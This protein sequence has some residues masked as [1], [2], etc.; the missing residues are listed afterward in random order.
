M[1]TKNIEQDV[2]KW[3]LSSE[4]V[5]FLKDKDINNQL[6]IAIKLKFFE[7]NGYKLTEIALIS[8]ETIDYIAKSLKVNKSSIEYYDWSGRSSRRH[9]DAIR[10]YLG[11]RETE[12]QDINNLK[13]LVFEQFLPLAMSYDVIKEKVYSHL[14]ALKIEPLAVTTMERLLRSWCYQFEEEFFAKWANTLSLED[15]QSIDR[16]I[17]KTENKTEP[18]EITSE[19][20][21]IANST[22]PTITLNI[23]SNKTLKIEDEFTLN[24]LK[25]N[26]GR[27]SLDTVM[28]GAKKLKRLKEISILS[29]I[30]PANI[31]QLPINLV[32]KYHQQVMNIFPSEL[33]KMSD[34][35]RY[36]VL[37]CFSYY[38]VM[39]LTDSLIDML[40][41]LVHKVDIKA[42]KKVMKE[43]WNNRRETYDKDRVLNHLAEI[44][45]NNPKGIIEQEIY[46]KVS[47]EVLEAVLKKSKG[48]VYYRE[49]KFGHMRSSYARHYRRMIS[50]IFAELD[51]GANNEYE[52]ILEA[53]S[54]IKKHK[55]SSQVFY[56]QSDIVPQ[57]NVII[58][59][60]QDLIIEKDNKEY[61]LC[62]YDYEP[63]DKE[64]KT[65]AVSIYSKGQ[66]LYYAMI[67]IEGIIR[68]N[69]VSAKISTSAR[70]SI[71]NNQLQLLT[72]NDKKIIL[73]YILRQEHPKLPKK[74][75]KISYEIAL[76]LSLQAK[77]R[78]KEIWVKS[79]AKYRNPDKDLP[80]DFEANRS[81]YYNALNQPESVEVFIAQLKQE[82]NKS[83]ANLNKNIPKNKKVKLTMKRGKSWIKLSPLTPQVEPDNIEK[84]KQEI[85]ISWPSVDLLD[86]LKEVELRED[87]SS[88]F[89]TIASKEALSSENLQ[90][91][92]LLTIFSLATNTGMK[93][94]TSASEV[95]YDDL[96]YVLRRYIVKDNLRSAI[97]KVINGNLKI[98][99]K[100]LFGDANISCA[101]D[102]TKC[103]A[104][105]QN[106]MTEW[107]VRY[108]GRGVMIY[109]HV[110]K[111]AL[112]VYSQLKTCSSSEIVAM[113]EGVIHHATDAEVKKN[114]VDSHGQSL[115]A[116]AFS[117][118][119]H[120]DL[121]PRLKLIGPEKLYLDSLANNGSYKNIES[122]MTRVIDWSLIA[123]Y[124][125]QIIQYATALRNKT[126][127]PEALLKR[128]TSNAVKHPVYLALQE[129]GRVIKTI[130][131]CRYLMSEEL[132]QEIQEGLNVI[133]R[134]NGV[135]DFI[136]YGRKSII[137]TND[138]EM[139]ELTILS[140]HLL[141]ACLVYINTLMIQHIL[142]LPHWQNRLTIEDKRA[143]SP[144]IYAHINPY[145]IFKLDMNKRLAI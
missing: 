80:Q 47:K 59:T 124:Y 53:I 55:D 142:K 33:L 85:A 22:E 127:E 43:F 111:K 12:K 113:I 71:K 92:L 91:K 11:F 4:E 118:L 31:E 83:L 126:A 60:Y 100:E 110:D 5:N 104:W 125:D 97:T 40:I 134:W 131:I 121:L 140:L 46:P 45:I 136:F 66:S 74:I 109:W 106:L 84:L 99:D 54:L 64:V 96:R 6:V 57:D 58:K 49:R 129:L 16:L 1:K 73:D 2:D 56:P 68:A 141:Q 24:D 139:Q 62:I 23:P 32:K 9:D 138:P 143:L 51:F 120:F 133:E 21:K 86:I 107:H 132:R 103:S 117:N 20:E 123:N 50:T 81:N 13:T 116:F 52:P 98:R 114:Y 29:S 82:L 28:S 39:S 94:V 63:S 122:I 76:L 115:V 30:N 78:C 25:Y 137:S 7:Y 70:D 38:Q 26:L 65:N 88:S 135:N 42:K 130:F 19:A 145:G 89:K 72:K 108:G 48:E 79:A 87:L 77:L 128:F 101:S 18:L 10:N 90:H 34:N 75:N 35:K 67:G 14:F 69:I 112:C 105:D 144:L 61:I 41:Q 3:S 95:S 44:S 119:L 93:R 17:Q 8:S 102:S 37:I 15:K 36:A 27:A